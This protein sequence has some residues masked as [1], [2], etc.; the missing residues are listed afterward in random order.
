MLRN[1]ELSA[2]TM[3]SPGRLLVT[4]W[5]VGIVAGSS[6]AL[7]NPT[8]GSVGGSPGLK[9]FADAGLGTDMTV[10]R[11]ISTPGNLNGGGS[12]EGG[13][14]VL[15]TGV[16]PGGTRT[17]RT[18]GDDAYA[19]GPSFDQ[20]LLKNAAA[21]QSP[22]TGE[23][24]ANSIVD[25]RTDFAE[26]STKC[27]S[28]SNST[29]LVTKY[30]GGTATENIPLLPVLSP[31]VQYT[32]LFSSFVPSAASDDGARRAA[33]GDAMLTQL[34]LRRSVLDFAAEELN[35]LR[36]MVPSEARSKLDNHY[37][38]IKNMETQLTNAINSGYS[39]TT[40]TGGSAGG[41]G[42]MGGSAG[43]VGGT[44]GGATGQ[45]GTGGV[46]GGAGSGGTTGSGGVGGG[47]VCGGGCSTKP[48]PPSADAIG[49]ADP[50]NG[51]G[52]NFG[53]D[54]GV[55]DDAPAHAAAGKAHLDVL[56]AAFV[57][58]LIRVG[59]FQWSPGSNHVA[60][61]G[62]F[63][64]EPST[65]YQHH[66]V[67]HRIGSA[68][69]MASATLAGLAGPAQFLFNIQLWYF[70]RHAENLASWKATIDGCGNPLL[71]YT[72]VPF[73]TEVRA[74]GHERSDMPGMI[75]GG[76]ALGFAH[77]IYR[78]GACTINQYWGTIAQ[79][80]DYSSPALPFA[81]PLPGLWTRPA[82]T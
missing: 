74:T 12:H 1:L 16:S 66:P 61:Q 39:C 79:A 22:L 81:D 17:N 54:S 64:N 45:G 7:W 19:A 72:V 60:F 35:Q 32:N 73:L 70:A 57:C 77:N 9:P 14:V 78:A 34:A 4:H 24:F 46:S 71:D 43:G 62:M 13:T 30:S 44:G 63:P 15:V 53:R 56:K 50:T 25:S 33:P 75:I 27:L 23:S 76:K 10:L 26:V 55:N 48:E 31:L 52:N 36:G 28:Y 38:A 65:I 41:V 47:G 3:R 51:F 11:G 40:G 18:E 82:G 2:Q 21:L 80:F 59:T 29:Q 5:P 68:E 20:I 58:D 37:F 42:G 8:S 49:S 6:N 69:T 67:S